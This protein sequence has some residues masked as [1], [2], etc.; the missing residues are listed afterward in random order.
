M[1]QIVYI[2]TVAPGV[3]ESEV[4]AILAQ[5]RR[6]NADAGITGLL[7]FDGKRFM[8]ALEGSDLAVRTTLARI[9]DDPRHRA[10]V[11][12][13]S[14][15]IDQ[16]EFGAWAMAARRTERDRDA[17]TDRIDQLVAGAAPVVR[18]HFEGFARIRPA[19]AA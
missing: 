3:G 11:T 4:T 15:I 7:Y 18:A 13:S 6:N 16:S 8:Q 17:V 1:L 9:A 5:S 19:T 2:S 12:L 14:R 10:M